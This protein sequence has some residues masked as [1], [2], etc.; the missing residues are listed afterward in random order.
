MIAEKKGIS[1]HVKFLGWVKGNDKEKLLQQCSVFTLPSYHEGMPMAILE[2]MSYGLATV[3]TNAGG[4][5]QIITDDV[6]GYRIEAGD[7]EA[8]SKRLS[9]LLKNDKLKRSIGE[10]A[11][12]RI[13]DKFDVRV[14]YAQLLSIYQEVLR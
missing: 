6:D 4:I 2:A 11:V 14:S 12:E 13:R 3:S 10:K 8:L 5:P 7:V 1:D 9:K